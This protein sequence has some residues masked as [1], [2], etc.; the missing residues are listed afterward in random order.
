MKLQEASKE[1][2]KEKEEQQF[3]VSHRQAGLLELLKPSH[4]RDILQMCLARK[5]K[6]RRRAGGR[7]YASQRQGGLLLLRS[8]PIVR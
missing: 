3:D 7:L 1:R 5:G 2:K 6:R 8:L 4:P